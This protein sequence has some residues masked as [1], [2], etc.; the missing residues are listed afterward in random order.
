MLLHK[1]EIARRQIESACELFF[2]G[3]DFL[4]VVTLAG[5]AEE[6]L[7]NLIQRRGEEAIIDYLV[8][9][10][11]KLTGGREFADV[12][13][14]ING[15]RNGLKH[16]KHPNEDELE[17]EEGEAIAMLSRAV[18]NYVLFT[19]GEATPDM[20]RVYGHLREMHSHTARQPFKPKGNH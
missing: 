20:V 18:T 3:A 15:I 14:D 16:A 5:A 1:A 13:K 10:D 2:S 11:S 12:I 8:G 17:V 7:G 4:A 6:I 19:R 9:L